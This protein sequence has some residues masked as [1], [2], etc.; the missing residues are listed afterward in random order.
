MEIVLEGLDARH[1]AA[2]ADGPLALQ[3]LSLG[4]QAGEHLAVIGPSGAG[5]TSLLQVLATGLRPTS[6][7]L[8]LDGLDP[9][10]LGSRDL[11]RLRS[12]IFYAPQ[13]PPLP[14]RQRV[15]TALSSA[16]LP[17]L[18]TAVSLLNLLRPRFAQESYDAL[19]A[20]D[21]GE[22]LWLRVDRLSGGERQRIGLAKAF[23]SSAE[24]WLVDE[25]LSALDPKRSQQAIAALV[26]EANRRGVTL[27]TTLHQV[28]VARQMFPRVI[29][30]RDG[31]LQ[32]DL[33]RASVTDQALQHLYAQFE[34]E[35]EQTSGPLH[36]EDSLILPSS[37]AH[38]IA[39]R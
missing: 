23:M 18:S 4:V 28:E 8:S 37:S 34:H 3:S 20:F 31:Q 33:P 26:E 12:R 6:G 15:V 39:C 21:L 35:L 22:K 25:P 30:L 16:K 19:C 13:I 24:L 9:W 11:R 36:P 14:P 5:K 2:A 10:S 17:E 1:R 38:V 27:I 32:F 7:R 29:G